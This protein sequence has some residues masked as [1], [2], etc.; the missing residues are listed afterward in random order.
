MSIFSFAQKKGPLINAHYS[1]KI[2]SVFGTFD[3]FNPPK[4]GDSVDAII[5][6]DTLYVKFFSAK[7]PDVQIYPPAFKM[8]PNALK[9]KDE[10]KDIIST[11]ETKATGSYNVK[12]AIGESDNSINLSIEI[13]HMSD[14]SMA[15]LVIIDEYMG[16][17]YDIL[18]ARLNKTK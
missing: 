2:E 13:V 6:S 1:G 5:I 15:N 7:N 16:Y 11:T 18:T 4:I 10:Y 3:S 9:K 17:T 8:T 12:Y 14:G